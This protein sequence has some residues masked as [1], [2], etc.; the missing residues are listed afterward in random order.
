MWNRRKDEEYAPRPAAPPAPSAE[1]VREATPSMSTTPTR[2]YEPAPVTSGSASIGKAVMVKGQIYSRED[3]YIDGE[4]E[5]NVEL[6]EHR[7]TV[8]PNGKVKAGIKAREIVA[9]GNIQGNVE[10]TDK[11]EIRKDA[12][13]IGDIKTARIVIEDGAYFKGGIDIIRNDGKQQ[14]APAARAVSQPAAPAPQPQAAQQPQPVGAG[15]NNK[16]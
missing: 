14:N 2:N 10:A 11:V 6:A 13:L 4:V 9:L 5:G 16:R 1:S 12:R 3:L 8:G 7:L 15:D